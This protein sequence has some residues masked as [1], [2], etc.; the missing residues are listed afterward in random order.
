MKPLLSVKVTRDMRHTG[1]GDYVPA[2][3]TNVAKTIAKARRELARQAQ[4]NEQERASKVRE[5][6]RRKA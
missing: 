2:C 1:V 4:Q 6:T 5:L 3:S